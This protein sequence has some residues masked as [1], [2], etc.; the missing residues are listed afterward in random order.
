MIVT[1]NPIAEARYEGD[2]VLLAY[3]LKLNVDINLVINQPDI[4]YIM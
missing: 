2:V 4:I 1:L 3:P